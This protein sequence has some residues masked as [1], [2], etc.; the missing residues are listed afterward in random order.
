MLEEDPFDIVGTLQAQAFRVERVVA[1]GGFGVVYRAHHEAFRAPVALKCLKVP[2]GLSGEQR[3]SFLEKFRE[4]AELLFRLSANIQEVVRPL[5]FG[6]LETKGFV[7]FLA[8]E[9]LE[10]ETLDAF[11]ERRAI[12]GDPPLGLRELVELLTPLALALAKAHHFPGPDGAIA[13]IHRDLKPE[14]VFLV[15]KPG[16]LRPKVLDFGIAR[17]RSASNAIV[18][19]VTR[20]DAMQAFSPG[21][22]APEQWDSLSFGAP[23]PWTDVYGLA[24][25]L[26]HALL[27][28]MPIDGDLKTMGALALDAKHRPSPRRLGAPISEAAERAFVRALAVHPRERTASID[29]FWAELERAAGIGTKPARHGAPAS[30]RVGAADGSSDGPPSSGA[31]PKLPSLAPPPLEAPQAAASGRPPLASAP[32]PLSAVVHAAA[33][34]SR[35]GD[36]PRLLSSGVELGVERPTLPRP[37]PQPSI[38]TLPHRQLHHGG[39]LLDRLAGPAKLLALALILAGLDVALRGPQGEVY[40]VEGMRPLWFAIAL[41]SVALLWGVARLVSDD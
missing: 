12:A 13:V 30:A 11:V 36:A 40:S 18:G 28:R 21:Y 22:A 14:N 8:L 19:L 5:H 2:G 23:G 41:A 32:P 15:G 7:P 16:E 34:A 10:G 4:E 31:L 33:P 25:T 17:V 29:V 35:Q 3:G 1:E 9:W 37:R 27:G 6:V 39:P 20:Q 26:T 38:S 24:I